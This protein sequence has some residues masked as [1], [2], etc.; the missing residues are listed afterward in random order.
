MNFFFTYPSTYIFSF[1]IRVFF[2]GH[3][4]PIGQQRKG[5]DHLLFHST[6]ST[7]SRTFRHT[8]ATLHVRWL[9]HFFNRT[10][11]IFQ[12]A[13]QWDLPP[14][15]ITI[16]FSDDV[17]LIFVCLLGDLILGFCYSNLRRE[18]DG[19]ELASTITLSLQVKRLTKCA[20]YPSTYKLNI[21]SKLFWELN[22]NIFKVPYI[23][24]AKY[25]KKQPEKAKKLNFT[26]FWA[27]YF[28]R[29]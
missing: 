24:R 20:S 19:L 12:A 28:W 4:Q 23:L 27:L 11:C 7:R 29:Y 13:T 15:R 5:G 3:W 25:F 16:W 26:I 8:F 6:S 2:H 14:C 10:P 1:S 18:T 9:S 21:I 17:M 22:R